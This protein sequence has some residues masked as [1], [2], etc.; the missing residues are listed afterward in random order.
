[1]MDIMYSSGGTSLESE[2]SGFSYETESSG[3]GL[4]MDYG[5][6]NIMLE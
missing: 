4:E 5:D 6:A 2:T 3:I 1:M